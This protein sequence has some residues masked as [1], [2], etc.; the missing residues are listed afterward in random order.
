VLHCEATDRLDVR[1]SQIGLFEFQGPSPPGPTAVEQVMNGL[2]HVD[3][4]LQSSA[5]GSTDVRSLLFLLMLVL[6]AVQLARG[7]V[8]VPAISFLWYAIDLALGSTAVRQQQ[9]EA[10]TDEPP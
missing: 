6:A 3:R 9:A 1:L 5:S 7:R 10:K 4:A 8:L 2:V